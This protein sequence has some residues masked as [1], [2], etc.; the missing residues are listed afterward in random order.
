MVRKISLTSL[1]LLIVSLGGWATLTPSFKVSLPKAIGRKLAITL[2]TST[3]EY[4]IDWG[5]GK[6]VAGT[7]MMTS[8]VVEG[9]YIAVYGD[10]L[11]LALTNAEI[12]EIVSMDAPHLSVL[13][14]NGN[15]LTSLPLTKVESLTSLSLQDNLL[16]KMPSLSFPKLAT[17][18]LKGNHLQTIALDKYPS[19]KRLIL[20]KNPLE[21]VDAT[22]CHHL[23]SLR[24]EDSKI[25]RIYFPLEKIEELY[26][27]GNKNLASIATPLVNLPRIKRIRLNGN[28]HTKLEIKDCPHLTDIEVR[29]NGLQGLTL[30]NTPSLKLLYLQDN[31]LTPKALESIFKALPIKAGVLKIAGNPEVETAPISLAK[32]KGWKV[33]INP[34]AVQRP[35]IEGVDYS[36]SEDKNTLVRWLASD[37]SIVDFRKDAILSK[38]K[39]IG[40]GAFMLNLAVEEVK[41]PDALEEIGANAFLATPLKR[42]TL[43]KSLKKLGLINKQP[44]NPFAEALSFSSIQVAPEN[45]YFKVVEGLLYTKDGK[46]LIVAPAGAKKSKIEIP[47]GTTKV[48][49]FAFSGALYLKEVL[50]PL[51]LLEIAPYAF[52]TA[53]ILSQI[54]LNSSLQQI[55]WAAFMGTAIEKIFLPKDLLPLY[56]DGY[57]VNFLFGAN[58]LKTI[59]LETG[60]KSFSIEEGI[61][62]DLYK[63]VLFAMP[64]TLGKEEFTL[65]SSVNS[66]AM[67]A[68]AQNKTLKKLLIRQRLAL[69]LRLLEGSESL[70]ELRLET[71]TPFMATQSLMGCKNLK[72]LILFSPY[73]P[74]VEDKDAFEA[75]NEK[76]QITIPKGA[77]AA[78]SQNKDWMALGLPF[79]E[80]APLYKPIVLYRGDSYALEQTASLEMV[81]PIVAP[82]SKERG[83]IVG[84]IVGITSL[85][86]SI[87]G[88]EPTIYW[89]EVKPQYNHF[90]EP[91]LRRDR[92]TRAMIDKYEKEI[93]GRTEVKEENQGFGVMLTYKN[94]TIPT[95]EVK[96]L[97]VGEEAAPYTTIVWDTP[98][99]FKRDNI[100][101]YLEERY[102]PASG[103]DSEGETYK[104]FVSADGVGYEYRELA[105][106]DNPVV[107]IVY[108]FAQSVRY[109]KVKLPNYLMPIESLNQNIQC[110]GHILSIGKGFTTLSVYNMQG[111]LLL[112]YRLTGNREE[113]SLEDLPCDIFFVS[114]LDDAGMRKETAIMMKK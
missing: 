28:N 9:N 75:V 68:F 111:E 104:G 44:S 27:S 56:E 108:F 106:E 53:G 90:V 2:K 57:A 65:P 1:F 85:I 97:F 99:S 100:T 58:H 105:V 80:S 110:N 67:G 92:R 11:Q 45:R 3:G 98:E 47:D 103:V 38:I 26:L 112:N 59:E 94:P 83:G 52:A 79:V 60:N 86:S 72:R 21:E 22:V 8:G 46:T 5:N 4:Q 12:T 35:L 23:V 77:I 96:Y 25:T 87:K 13:N 54:K 24:V 39:K 18:N 71:G 7:K 14:L 62:Y 29:D 63:K 107:N 84:N 114:V 36:L 95:I 102:A 15:K 31:L 19:L 33:D 43:P 88:Q 93:A 41:L 49:Q 69:P 6:L 61:L 74:I 10:L 66:L 42:I 30:S 48:A 20:S 34:N 55:G 37:L 16:S 91:Y 81:S 109:E 78:Y 51:S 82:Y 101:A 113:F 89:V 76:L 50:C 70:E 17:L 32:E 64:A 40:E 73:P